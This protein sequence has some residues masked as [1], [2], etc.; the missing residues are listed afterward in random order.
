[1]KI[2]RNPSP[3]ILLNRH[4]QLGY[5]SQLFLGFTQGLL[6]PHPIADVPDD[7]RETVDLPIRPAVSDDDLRS[8]NFA[9]GAVA[10]PRLALPQTVFD[11]DRNGNVPDI[12]PYLM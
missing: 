11:C 9:A 8:V 3:L 7:G 6:R 5:P 2:Q 1:M 4:Q 10:Q 12:L